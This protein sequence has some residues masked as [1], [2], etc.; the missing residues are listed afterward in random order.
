VSLPRHG[1]PARG[2]VWQGLAAHVAECAQNDVPQ[3]HGLAARAAQSAIAVFGFMT[4]KATLRERPVSLRRRAEKMPWKKGGLRRACIAHPFDHLG[5]RVRRPGPALFPAFFMLLRL[6]KFFLLTLTVTMVSL[7]VTRALSVSSSTTSSPTPVNPAPAAT[8]PDTAAPAAKPAAPKPGDDARVM[9][10]DIRTVIGDPILYVLR[11]GLKEAEDKGINVI[12][13]DMK[14]PGGAADS[15]MAIMEAL[16]RFHGTTITYVNDEAISAGAFIAAA[17]D[18]IWFAPGGVIGAAAAVNSD[19]N[20]IPATMRLKLNSFLRAKIRAVTEGRGYRGQVLSAMIDPDYELKIDGQVIKPKGE[21]LSL[22][23][24]EAMKTHGE[25]PLPLL[26]AGVAPDIDTLLHQ[27][28]GAGNFAITRLQVTW[29]EQL[30]QWLNLIKPALIGLGMMALFIEFKTPGF[31]MFGIAGIVLLAIVFLSSYVAGLSG[32]EPM[33]VFAIGILLIVG[34]LVLHPGLIV[35]IVAGVALALGALVWAMTDSWPNEPITAPFTTGA[36]VNPLFNLALGL[37]IA[38]AL[39]IFLL[40]YMP[41]SWFW[42]RLELAGAIGGAAQIAG[43]P[44]EEAAAI[45]AL[46]GRRGTVITPL[47]PF[48]QVEIDGRHYEARLPLGTAD[49]GARI[50][51][52]GQTDFSLDVEQDGANGPDKEARA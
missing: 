4:R 37:V 6:L 12:V 52:R 41:K 40:R 38:A 39:I 27:R 13:L 30:A 33:I 31:G 50:I 48:G 34:E 43:L 8:A 44:P 24:T 5:K 35:P 19:G 29:S 9:V 15:A 7:V 17:T 36:L 2:F 18:E 16:G 21:L 32:H 28:F 49:A 23:D 51:V 25:P 1:L 3:T 10:I 45:G 14:T 20:E 26:G 47:R 11:R 42:D 46:I 22:T